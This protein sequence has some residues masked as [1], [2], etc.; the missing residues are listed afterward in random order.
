VVVATSASNRTVRYG[1]LSIRDLWTTL[2]ALPEANL[3]RLNTVS[4]T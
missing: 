2:P 3:I 4:I 1:M